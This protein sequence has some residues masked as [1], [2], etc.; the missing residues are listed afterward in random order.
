M[1][2]SPTMVSMEMSMGR[3]VDAGVDDR[4]ALVARRDCSAECSW[5]E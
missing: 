3:D 1:T 2:N 4:A 5:A